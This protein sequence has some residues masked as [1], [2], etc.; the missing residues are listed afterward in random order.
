M[1]YTIAERMEIVTLYFRNGKN[2]HLTA[3]LFNQHYPNK[4]CNA[5]YVLELVQKFQL[6]GSVAN[7]R[8][9]PGRERPVRNEAT[10]IGIL[11]QVAADPTLS[12]RKLEAVTSISRTTIRWILKAHNFHP[13]KIN[14]VH[15]LNED[16][17][18]RRQQF[19]EIMTE[20]LRIDVDYLFNICFSDECTFFLNSTVNRHNCR[21]W[22]D[23]NPSIF[24]EVHSQTPQ[25]LNV[26][27]GIFGDR[28][29]GPIFLDSNQTGESY[30]DL[31]ENVVHPLLVDIVELDDRYLED[32]L[33]FQ[34]DGAPPHCA[35][36]VIEFLNTAFSGHWIGRRGPLEWPARSPDL[37]PLDF[38][39]WGHLKSKIYATEPRSLEELRQR[40][41]D[42]CCQITP[43]T[44][45]SVRNRFEQNLYY[46]MEVSG[47]QF[48]HLLNT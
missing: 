6:M 32:R 14:L 4:H 45:R 38:F 46:C 12:T 26:W 34:Q 48:E 24:H 19:C 3:N 35:R 17:F 47:A 15:Q 33:T 9:D 23:N 11:G 8:R 20:R 39:L 31:L 44:F 40:I 36:S 2:A 10:E 41:I 18:D 25:K 29:L 28:L 5:K 30:L 1:T 37:S 43:E 27:A 21:Y 16:D 7:K 42:E 13:Y 22:S